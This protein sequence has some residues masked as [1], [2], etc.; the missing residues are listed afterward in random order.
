[1]SGSQGFVDS[2]VAEFEY[3][4][5]REHQE[6]LAAARAVDPSAR[7]V[8]ITMAE[9]YADQAWSLVEHF[10]LPIAQGVDRIDLGTNSVEMIVE[11]FWWKFGEAAGEVAADLA[12][13]A[14]RETVAIWHHVVEKLNRRQSPIAERNGVSA[15]QLTSPSA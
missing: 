15:P 12:A 3:F 7:D 14:C 1:M 9:R 5:L 2:M 4:E 13:A 8:H 11:A 10:E 6:R